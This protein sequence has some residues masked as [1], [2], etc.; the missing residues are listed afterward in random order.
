MDCGA[1]C[2][3]MITDYYG[4][5]YSID[6]IRSLCGLGMLGVSM[7]G[8]CNA[9]ETIGFRTIAGKV[10]YE[11]LCHKAVLPCILHWE[12]NH[13]VV[14]YKVK[15]VFGRYR[16]YVADPGKAM[17]VYNEREFVESW[18]STR[19][20]GLDKGSLILMEPSPLFYVRKATMPKTKET[21]KNKLIYLWS[22]AK[23]YKLAF[24]QIIYGLIITSLIFLITP[25]LTKSIVDFG[26]GTRNFPFI[27]LV[28]GGQLALMIGNV[29]IDFL[30]NR[31]LLHVGT[32]IN[33]SLIS[34]FFIKLMKMP[35]NFFD[36]KM[37]GDLLQR[38]E[39]HKRVENFLTSL[40]L[41]VI[42]STFAFLIY[43]IVLSILNRLVFM[44]FLVGAVLYGGWLLLFLKKRRR[45]DYKYFE[46]MAK[47]NDKTYQIL[48][49]IQETKLHNAETR[50]R[51]EWEDIQ[52]DLFD[53]NMEIL[54]LQ[55]NRTLGSVFITQFRN[56]LITVT[57]AMSV[58]NGDI[59]LGTMLAIQFIVGELNSP[60]EQMLTLVYNWQDITMSLER[61]NSIQRQKE[62]NVGRNINCYTDD[63][64]T[65]YV[66]SLSFQYPGTF[67]TVLNGVSFD[68]P[69]GKVTA[70]VGTSGSGK[71][72]LLKLILG[73]YENYTGAIKIGNVSLDKINLNWWRSECGVVMQNGYIYS[74]TIAGNI[75]VAELAPDKSKLYNAAKLANVVEIVD[76]L[77]MK[78]NTII[79]DNGQGL[80]QGQKQRILIARS[81]YKNPNYIFLD[82][83]TNSLDANNEREIAEKLAEFYKGKTVLV[84]AHR[85][86]TVKNADQ[87][88]VLEEG[89]IVE[90]GNHEQL[91]AQKGKYFQLVKN[92]L[93]LGD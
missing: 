84:I 70:I 63:D 3:K 37:L 92:Q 79:G 71:S 45:L 65:I 9:L 52:A 11:D 4:S 23:N 34:D 66:E 85:L 32:R 33:I 47:N 42:Y 29:I 78:F 72:T 80:S 76:Q 61:I 53:V 82:E 18:I 86:S 62:E 25:F 73:Y 13:F 89:H 74:D 91:I 19:S 51:W 20:H 8:I 10:S 87:I 55:Q 58:L 35:M 27:M 67:K 54:K 2:I 77:P 56:I 46:Q 6:Y 38:I 68:I 75:A 43:G 7:K 57:A 90:K 5:E 93:E 22:Y 64:H 50:K 60:I 17:M 49:S 14:L 59:T 69:E 48:H 88:I 41:N 28:L 21:E 15:K 81:V 83:A 1:A 30:R 36:T 40:S 26:I 24:F 16:F 31:L 39:D 44:I 12:Q